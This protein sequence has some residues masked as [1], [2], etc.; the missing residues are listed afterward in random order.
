ME[1]KVVEIG[2]HHGLLKR[3]RYHEEFK[4]NHSSNTIVLF[5]VGNHLETYDNDARTIARYLGITLSK[6]LKIDSV[7]FPNR[8]LDTYLPK[9]IRYGFSIAIIGKDFFTEIK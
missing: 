9:L 8:A 3:M 4:Y 1:T 6:S 5:E 7:E 2:T